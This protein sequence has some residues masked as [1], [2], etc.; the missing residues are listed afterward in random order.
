MIKDSNITLIYDDLENDWG[1]WNSTTL[2]SYIIASG[3]VR[4]I[5]AGSWEISGLLWWDKMEFVFRIFYSPW[6]THESIRRDSEKN[7]RIS[8]TFSHYRFW[9]CF[10]LYLSSS[11]LYPGSRILGKWWK[12]KAGPKGM[13]KIS[14]LMSRLFG[15][16]GLASLLMIK[17]S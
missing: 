16:S 4:S 2:Y 14:R 9:H 8:Q 12:H 6:D 10:S 7:I 1:C 15:T 17:L 3:W 13:P 11:T 5:G